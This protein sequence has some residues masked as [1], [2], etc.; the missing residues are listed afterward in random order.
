MTRFRDEY[1]SDKGKEWLAAQK[2]KSASTRELIELAARMKVPK[3]KREV[4][5]DFTE[6]LRDY[7]I[8]INAKEK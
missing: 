2:N 6:L 5:Q 7:T 4:Q 8:T 3:V 1:L